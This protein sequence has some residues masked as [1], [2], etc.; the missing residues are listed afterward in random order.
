MAAAGRTAPRNIW[1]SRRAR[2]Q[3]TLDTWVP[4]AVAPPA[5]TSVPEDATAAE[6]IMREFWL[7]LAFKFIQRWF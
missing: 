7:L 4:V 3:P 6:A 5:R 2:R 1:T